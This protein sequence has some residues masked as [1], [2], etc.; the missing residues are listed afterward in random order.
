MVS[1]L[2]DSKGNYRAR[3]RLPE[4]VRE[5]Y[6]RQYRAGF[7]AKKTWPASTP[8]KV[9]ERLFHEWL[10]EVEQRIAA[11]RALLKGSHASH[12]GGPDGRLHNISVTS[13]F[14]LGALWVCERFFRNR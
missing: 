3:K 12:L 6:A 10:A 9:V 13:T 8:R 5:E 14:L 7:E 4:D 1:L 2:Q 11:I